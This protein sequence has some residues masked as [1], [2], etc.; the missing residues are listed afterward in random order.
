V[1]R[2][3]VISTFSGGKGL[4]IVVNREPVVAA[5]S[6]IV[7][8]SRRR[9]GIELRLVVLHVSLALLAGCERSA[10]SGD[11]ALLLEIVL[12]SL[13]PLRRDRWQRRLHLTNVLTLAELVRPAGALLGAGVR[14]SPG[15][16]CLPL[17]LIKHFF[18]GIF[19]HVSTIF[20][21]AQI[22]SHF[23]EHVSMGILSR[24]IGIRWVLV[25]VGLLAVTILVLIVISEPLIGL[26]T[27]V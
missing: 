1:N 21:V 17:R 26:S 9:V 14:D 15:H 6:I 20:I 7:C 8:V 23:L 2:I 27:G 16:V 11:T 13:R 25:T 24:H 3:H 18:I 4:H 19:H 5:I 10:R 22:L 12:R